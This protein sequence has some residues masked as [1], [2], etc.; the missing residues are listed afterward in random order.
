MRDHHTPV[1]SDPTEEIPLSVLVAA[2]NRYVNGKGT[3]ISLKHCPPA[4][5]PF[6]GLRLAAKHH[7]SVL[8]DFEAEYASILPFFR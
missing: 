8:V 3:G 1:T 5:E 6:A 4:E 2:A 7:E